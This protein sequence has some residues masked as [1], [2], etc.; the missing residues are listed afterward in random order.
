MEVEPRF[1]AQNGMFNIKKLTE[2]TFHT[3]NFS[4]NYECKTQSVWGRCE[5]LC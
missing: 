2:N 3:M 1:L 4:P 5:V